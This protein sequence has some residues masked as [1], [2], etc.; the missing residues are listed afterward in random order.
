MKIIIFFLFQCSCCALITAIILIIFYSVILAST[1]KSWCQNAWRNDIWLCGDDLQRT[2]R[3]SPRNKVH[4]VFVLSTGSLRSIVTFLLR[5]LFW[6]YMY[7]KAISPVDEHL[8]ALRCRVEIIRKKFYVMGYIFGGSR[9][10][11][12]GQVW[13]CFCV[14]G[15]IIKR[16]IFLTKKFSSSNFALKML[17]KPLLMQQKKGYCPRHNDCNYWLSYSR[18]PHQL[19]LTNVFAVKPRIVMPNCW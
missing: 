14:A 2:D 7:I 15:L 5:I 4:P 10:L 16:N 17:M 11:F 12:K 1:A 8:P 6:Y 9:D 18:T 19:L 13:G 3:Q